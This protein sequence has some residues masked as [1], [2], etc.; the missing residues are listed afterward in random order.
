MHKKQNRKPETEQKQME[1]VDN[2]STF[3]FNWF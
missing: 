3:N 1:T 2:L